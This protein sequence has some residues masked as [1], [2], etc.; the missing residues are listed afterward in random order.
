M[1]QSL[2]GNLD[3]KIIIRIQQDIL[4]PH[5]LY[6]SDPFICLEYKIYSVKQ[7]TPPPPPPPP[8]FLSN[9]ALKVTKAI[10]VLRLGELLF[11]E[12]HEKPDADD[13]LKQERDPEPSFRETFAKT[14]GEIRKDVAGSDLVGR[15][16]SSEDGSYGAEDLGCDESEGDVDAC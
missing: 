11:P 7:K 3:E 8:P 4:Y 14:G 6:K 13:Q 1:F 10:H 2:I 16:R 9:T 5:P 12:E 15:S